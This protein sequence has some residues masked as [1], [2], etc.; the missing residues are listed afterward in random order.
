MA[1]VEV[2]KSVTT[3]LELTLNDDEAA[4]LK[5]AMQNALYGN[6]TAEIRAFREKIFNALS[7]L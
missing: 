6:E 3:V 7:F 5:D 4:F 1:H 2:K